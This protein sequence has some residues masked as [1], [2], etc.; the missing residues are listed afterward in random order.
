MKNNANSIIDR[1]PYEDRN[2]VYNKVA[3][4]FLNGV[5]LGLILGGLVTFI[6]VSSGII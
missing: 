1:L 3:R 4:V 2:A 5:L 6:F